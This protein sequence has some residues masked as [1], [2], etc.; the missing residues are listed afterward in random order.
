MRHEAPSRP[1]LT[2]LMEAYRIRVEAMS[3]Q[4][5]W[6]TVVIKGDNSDFTE[7]LS[8]ASSLGSDSPAI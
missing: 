6:F 8:E 2:S 3:D 4:S 1:E 5:Q 7:K